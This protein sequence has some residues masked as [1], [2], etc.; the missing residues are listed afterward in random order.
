MKKV[1]AVLLASLMLLSVVPF[2][3]FAKVDKADAIVAEIKNPSAYKHIQYVKDKKEFK[4]DRIAMGVFATYD[5]AWVNAFT[6]NVD[7]KYAE[8]LLLSI[9]EKIEAE[10]NNET[11]EK[12][13]KVLEGVNTAAGVVEKIDSYTHVL[14]LAENSSWG[15]AVQVLGYAV[16]AGNMANEAYETYVEAFAR[17]LSIQ[18]ASIYYSELLDYIIANVDGDHEDT[19]KDAARNIKAQ[20]TEN[21]DAAKER[22]LA[23][24]AA[25]IGKEAG[26]V[27]ISTAMKTNTVT[28]VIDTV[29]NLSGTIGK[30]VFNSQNLYEYMTSLAEIVEIEDCVPSYVSAAESR[31]LMPKFKADDIDPEDVEL[32]EETKDEAD[33]LAWSFAINALLT[34]H[35]TGE[36][37]LKKL[38]DT[39][40]SSLFNTI[41]SKINLWSNTDEMNGL[42]KSGAISCAKLNAYRK[43]LAADK[44]VTTYGVWVSTEKGKNALVYNKDNQIVG[45]IISET[46]TDVITDEVGLFAENDED[47]GSFIKVIVPLTEGLYATYPNYTVGSSSS[48]SSSSGGGSKGGFSFGSIFSGLFKS[49]SDFFSNLFSMF[50]F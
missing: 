31:N 33:D 8:G 37:L 27:A 7:V 13:L 48:S 21:L 3:A 45:K 18:A 29:Y 39:K 2:A 32:V 1:L 38:A 5:D 35:E 22:I 23:E 15:T 40:S 47:L 26:Y 43:L 25:N 16:K 41:G 14:D 34:L 12:V 6:D 28:A 4:A 9:I 17:V 44:T 19:I 42:I 24:L 46:Q 36:G 50:K 11:F 20:I 49:L 30:K 10:Y